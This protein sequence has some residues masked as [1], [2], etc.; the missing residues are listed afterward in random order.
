VLFYIVGDLLILRRSVG[1]TN[2][3]TKHSKKGGMQSIGEKFS[4]VFEMAILLWRSNKK[5]W[6]GRGM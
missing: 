4:E 1:V 6:Y 2:V 5:G 3:R